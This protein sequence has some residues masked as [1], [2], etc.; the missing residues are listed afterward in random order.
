[1]HACVCVCARVRDRNKCVPKCVQTTPPLVVGHQS[2]W[3][4]LIS[5]LAR[6]THWFSRSQRRAQLIQFSVS[7][8][9][10]SD[11]DVFRQAT[12]PA[13]RRGLIDLQFC[14][15]H[16]AGRGLFNLFSDRSRVRSLLTIHK[17]SLLIGL[18]DD[19]YTYIWYVAYIVCMT[20][21]QYGTHA[22]SQSPVLVQVFQ[23]G[24]LT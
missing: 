7:P 1:M 12:R 14:T 11:D 18:I 23:C 3:R 5:L 10:R 15:L 24:R 13:G 17:L 19:T 20:R 8:G 2:R 16:T 9:D 4:P 6:L 22:R 21:I